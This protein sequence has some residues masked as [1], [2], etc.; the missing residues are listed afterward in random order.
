MAR[1][2]FFCIVDTETTVKDQVADFAALIVDREGKIFAQCAVLVRGV[3]GEQ[4]LFHDANK[5]NIWGFEGLRKR[6]Q[7]YIA[8][9]ESGQRMIASVAAINR[10]L[11]QAVGKYD[12]ALTAY[13]L[14]FDAGKCANTAIDLGIFTDRFCL[15]QA[16]VGN[17]CQSKR[18]RQFC[19]ENH[20]FNAPTKLGNMT[21]KT[22]AES[23]CGFVR[24][25]FIT[26][27]HTALE[28]ARDF[29]LPILQHIIRRKGW[30]DKI[31]PHAWQD[32]QVRNHFR[33]V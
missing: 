33:A 29:E 13:N 21:Y 22:D 15:W 16:S 17:I 27:P 3:Y 25:E 7:G 14:S 8:M 20:L 5:S 2:Q 18:F 6:E 10:W 32:F 11:N 30:R 24:G 19:M 4:T 9:L 23:V 26:E 1:K 28:D 12:P 31:K